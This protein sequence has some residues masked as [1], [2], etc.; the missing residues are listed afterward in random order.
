MYFCSECK[1]LHLQISLWKKKE[2]KNIEEDK[3]HIIG[4]GSTTFFF[5]FSKI[6]RAAFAT[7]SNLSS[8]P[9]FGLC[10]CPVMSNRKQR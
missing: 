7:R 5:F 3:G 8:L 1:I 6:E 4:R 10:Y 2:K 9:V